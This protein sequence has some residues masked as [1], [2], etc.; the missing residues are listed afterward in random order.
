MLS[1]EQTYMGSD[2]SLTENDTG[3]EPGW[4]I[5]GTDG[6]DT[7][8][9]TIYGEWIASYGG[10][11]LLQGGGGDDVLVAGGSG[12]DGDP[13]KRPGGFDR[14]YGDE[15]SDYLLGGD[16]GNLIHGGSDNDYAYGGALGD[17][18]N[19]DSGD[20][21][22]SG[23][24]GNDKVSGGFGNDTVMGGIGDDELV[25][26]WG[27]DTFRFTQLDGS[28]DVVSDFNFIPDADFKVGQGDHFEL[29]LGAFTALNGSSG[30]T[31]SEGEFAL[32]ASA[33]TSSQ[34][35]LYDQAEGALFYDPDG[36]GAA[37][38]VQFASLAGNPE[39]QASD[40]LLIL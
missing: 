21:F 9:G 30:G 27:A 16:G 32:G 29:S 6:D 13:V 28:V 37:E 35:I 26:G 23:N 17:K 14:L 31:L 2:S 15:G 19:G 1:N 4:P 5:W 12:F 8:V 3:K 11:D 24:G 10:S 36:N 20:D 18:I 33:T 38:A 39:L 7:L 34:H 40:F 22:L 25:G